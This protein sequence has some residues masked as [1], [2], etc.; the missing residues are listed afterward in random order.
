MA[1]Y[2]SATLRLLPMARLSGLRMSVYNRINHHVTAGIGSPFG[3]F[4]RVN[5]ASSHFHVFKSGEVEQFVDTAYRA[6]ADLDGSDATLS[7]ETEG[8]APGVDANVEPWTDAQVAA[9]ILLDLWI[10]Q[11]H[12]IATRLATD[13]K[14]GASSKGFSWHRLGIDG[15]FPESPSPYAGRKQRGG[16]MHYSNSTGKVCPGNA[17]ID[18]IPTIL[19]GVIAALNGSNVPAPITSQPITSQP[20]TPQPITPQPTPVVTPVSNVI[21]AGVSAPAFP[22]PSDSYFGPKS[23]P[24]QSVS[25]FYSHRNDLMSW[26]Q[27][28]KDRGWIISADGYYGDETK[29]IAR[30]FQTEKGLGVDGLIG[31][32]TWGAAWTAPITRN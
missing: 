20:I 25:G 6:E 31:P 18:Q 13:S 21:S 3:T 5:A 14:I 28:M 22:L 29:N 8:A 15:N 9:L 2:P 26:Q 27:R 17:K 23:G 12:G 30:L 19:A 4:N 24:T 1:I 11:T 7:I 32:E 16:G 10:V